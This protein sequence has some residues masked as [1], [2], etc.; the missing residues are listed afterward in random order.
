MKWLFLILA[1]LPL[2]AQAQC[3]PPNG[4]GDI[5]LTSQAQVDAFP[6]GCTVIPRGL[7]ITGA[8]ITSLKS[9]SAVQTAGGLLIND[10]PKL[11]NLTGLDNLTSVGGSLSIANNPILT[12]IASLSALTQVAENLDFGGNTQLANLTGL[13]SLTSIGNSLI[14]TSN[15]VLTNLNSL[16][17][18]TQLNGELQIVNN[19]QLANLIGL[20]NLTSIGGSVYIQR[21]LTLT[22]LTG[23]GA[24][25]QIGGELQVVNNDHLI[26]L[27]GL[28]QL[29]RVSGRLYIESNAA[30][31]SLFDLN[32]L[33]QLGGEL[34]ILYNAHLTN[35]SGLSKLTRVSRLFINN[36]PS[37]MSLNSLRG[38]TQID[39]QVF[40]LDNAQLSECAID[41]IC[42]YLAN[43]PES[44]FIYGN[45]AGCS[46]PEEVQNIC[47]NRIAITQPPTQSAVCPGGTVTA[48]VSTTGNVQT[49]QWY[50]GSQPVTGQ[51]TNTLSLTN[52]QADDAGMYRVVVSNSVSS[53]TSTAFTLTVNDNPV[54]TLT[55]NGPLSCAK[56]SVQLKV[57]STTTGPL[58]YSFRG[59]NPITQDGSAQATVSNGGTYTVTVT[60]TNGCSTMATTEVGINLDSPTLTLNNTG[61]LS[62]TNTSVT[63]TANPTPGGTYNYSFS[64]GA[65]QQGSPNK[66][67]VTTAGVY[68]VSVTRQDNGCSATAS[69]TVTGG[70]NPTVC[71]GGATVINV[72][73]A[74]DVVKYEWYK[75]SLSSPKLMET[76]QL[77]R[78]T[79]TSSLSLINAQSNTQGD[80]YLKVTERSGRVQVYGPYRLTV[81]GSCRAREVA[82]RETALEVELAPNPIQQERLRGVVRGAGGGALWVGLVDQRGKRLHQQRWAEAL[83]EQVIDWDMQGESSGVYVLEVVREGRGGQP[84]QRQTLKVIKAN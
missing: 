15:P 70:N 45:A 52:V 10:N 39:T 40:I 3:P 5:D 25:T 27:S 84:A 12:S 4:S 57:A 2:L 38:L 83:G 30:L 42:Q 26:N 6:P 56:T 74:G 73:V 79:A 82:D 1:I 60:G 55:N 35:L 32:T 75:N 22:S 54:V 61:P 19:A 28:S 33:T 20:N 8:D 18:V 16:S 50:K 14:I 64:Q 11:V 13:N 67:Q 63:L 43:S 51:T 31:T 36:N 77:F 24:L 65:I 9:L 58:S 34:R 72:L 78:G 68:S 37:L 21:N 49:Y 17:A 46:S 48:A 29:T 53:L 81:D 7:N 23:L 62:F 69:T 80:F 47:I 76:P 41:P 71:R 66:A 59:A 44:I